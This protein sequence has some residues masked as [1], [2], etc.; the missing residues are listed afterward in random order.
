MQ[1]KVGDKIKVTVQDEDMT[2][3]FE[4]VV[5]RI[6]SAG[7]AFTESGEWL[8]NDIKHATVEIL[9][10]A[11]PPFGTKVRTLY[12]KGVIIPTPS[13]RLSGVRFGEPIIAYTDYAGWADPNV[14][15]WEVNND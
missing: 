12:G 5:A 6:N 8:G 13:Y 15:K 7:A 9:E 11:L 2:T 3:T 10:Q 1:F 4:G 14:V